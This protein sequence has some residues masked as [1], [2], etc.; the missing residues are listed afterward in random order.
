M[1][2]T[3]IPEKIQNAKKNHAI[4][5]VITEDKPTKAISVMIKRL[6]AAR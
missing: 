5:R 4:I 1:Y 6:N 2:Y 3:S